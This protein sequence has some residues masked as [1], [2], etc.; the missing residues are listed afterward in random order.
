[1]RR[2]V[3]ALIAA[4]VAGTG[5]TGLLAP[6]SANAATDYTADEVVIRS[7]ALVGQAIVYTAATDGSFTVEWHLEQSGVPVAGTGGTAGGTFVPSDGRAR[8]TVDGT[9]LPDGQYDNVGTIVLTDSDGVTGPVQTF[10]GPVYVDKTGPAL[11]SITVSRTTIY[12][13]IASTKYPAKVVFRVTG[14]LDD[15]VR[16]S[17]VRAG[18]EWAEPQREEQNPD[19][20]RRL[21]WDGRA[22]FTGSPAV[23]AGVYTLTAYDALQNPAAVVAQVTVSGLHYESRVWRRTITARASLVDRFVGRCATLRSPGSRGWRG[24]LGLYA[25]T[26]CGS[27]QFQVGGVQT[28][29]A[30][31]VPVSASGKYGPISV[32][33]Y[34]GSARSKRGGTAVIGMLTKTDRYVNVYRTKS[35]VG[36][37]NAYSFYENQNLI[38][39]GSQVAWAANPARP[40][41][42][43]D[44]RT[45]YITVRYAVVTN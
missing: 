5:G 15:V 37:T 20:S 19:G 43:Y 29:H 30:V 13:R 22:G 36:R 2:F 25:N 40:G 26:K 31:K 24:S 34:G 12:P 39:P 28:L 8:F 14:D 33:T 38:L 32:D 27:R 23:P 45:F 42:R 41:D 7:G 16:Y 1:M 10:S 3:G 17:F 35:A 21:E 9:S 44:I 11:T 4:I 18:K 6:S